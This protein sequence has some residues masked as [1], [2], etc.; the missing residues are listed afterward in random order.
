MKSTY[1][2]HRH[3]S[4]NLE[5]FRT[6]LHD[7]MVRKGL[8]STDQRRLI[9]ET[10]FRSPNH[11]SIE[12]LLAQVRREDPRVGYATVYRT[13]KLLAECGV[14]NERRFSDGLTRYELA[15]EASHH[16]HLICLECSDI[17]EFEEERIEALQEEV[18]ERHG[19]LLR[20]H[21]H[22]MYGICPKCQKRKNGDSKE[23]RKN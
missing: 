21:K 16:D 5:H 6:I 13:L 10:F 3:D 7:H 11:V 23:R 22:E 14:A 17:V 8:R 20:S 2:D 19:F 9:V 4:P 12:E 15:D 18:A 1:E